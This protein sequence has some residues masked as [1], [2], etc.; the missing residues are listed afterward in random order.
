MPNTVICTISV[1]DQIIVM[2]YS[3]YLEML[4]EGND[5]KD[6]YEEESD[7]K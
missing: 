7:S 5:F 1:I 3:A 6:G 2:K 4:S